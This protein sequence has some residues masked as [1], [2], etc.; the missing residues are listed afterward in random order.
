M[1]GLSAIAVILLLG[2]SAQWIAW[3]LKLPSIL[4]LLGAG[5]FAGPEWTG[6]VDPDA[7][8]GD[9]LFPIVSASVAIIL[10]EGGLG[11]QF[12]D[13]KGHG[14]VVFRLITVGA[15]VTWVLA[16]AAAWWLLDLSAGMSILLGA[17]VIVSGPTVV[18]PLLRHI[19][20]RGPTSS[21][22][23][24]EGIL[25]DPVG[26]LMAVL[27]Y[28]GLSLG[29]L[30]VA[31]GHG[32]MGI[33][34]TLLYGG[35][36]GVLGGLLL[37]QIL[38][39]H[40]VPE[41][42]LGPLTLALV[43]G[44]FAGTNLLQ[45]ESGLLAVTAMGI[46][47]ANLAGSGVRAILEFKE[48]LRVL[49]ISALF[50]LLAARLTQEELSVLDWR[51]FAFLGLLLFVVRPLSVVASAWGS[52]LTRKERIFLAWICPRGIVAAAVASVFGLALVE[53][54]VPGAEMLLPVVFLVIVGT[55]VVY[56]LTAPILARRLGLSMPDPQ[57]C[58]FVGA[59][60]WARAL[61]K[62]LQE[63]DIEVL[64]LD[65]NRPNVRAA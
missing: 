40:L 15:L 41:T 11:L 20:P 30:D 35:G 19:H 63:C 51:A 43:V 7:L 65:T 60:G 9:L 59:H 57:G 4:L 56:G 62:A 24:W 12:S 39:H 50:I 48:N 47:A 52:T 8:L 37:V 55:V 29:S 17:I 16:G 31:A 1:S 6:L 58:L 14:A 38:K 46:V 53:Q 25:I 61:A 10:F 23:T 32:G 36:G 42:L 45:E 34:L 54:Q 64:M 13:L 22:L 21:I 5:F 18:G 26:A 33:L 2:M 27:V 28:E 44:I 49:L 3:R